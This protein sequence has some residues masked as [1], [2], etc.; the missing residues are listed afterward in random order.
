MARNHDRADVRDIPCQDCVV[1][2]LA[3]HGAAKHLGPEELRALRVLADAG[4]IAPLRANATPGPRTSRSARSSRTW[5][6]P[7]TRAS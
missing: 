5:V 4:M 1:A 6:F 7:A 2:V 3:P